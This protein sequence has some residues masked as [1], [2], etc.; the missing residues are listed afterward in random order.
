MIGRAA[1]RGTIALL[2]IAPVLTAEPSRAAEPSR[3]Y[4]PWFSDPARAATDAARSV[5]STLEGWWQ[6][7]SGWV[8]PDGSGSLLSAQV[9]D[10][11]RRFFAILEAIGLKLTE[12][13]VGKG[14]FPVATY[15]FTAAQEPS[16]EDVQRAEVLL[17][18]YRDDAAGF[19]PRAKQ[20][21]ARSVLDA[22]ASAGFTLSSVEV[23]L[24]PWPDASYQVV[25]RTNAPR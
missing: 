11:D 19:R 3:E 1:V 24:S 25:A 4:P 20:R 18:A 7:L 12:V 15:R 10:D 17:R 23:T 2:C 22:A 9:S 5:G 6:G 8:T 16:D 14:V 13:S 21:I